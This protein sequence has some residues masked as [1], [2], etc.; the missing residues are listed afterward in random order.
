ME[1]SGRLQPTTFSGAEG[2]DAQGFLDK[3]QRMLRTIGV[4]ETSGVAFTTFQFSGAAFT[5]WETF[6]RRRP[7]SI[8]PLTWQQFSI[9]FL[10]KYVP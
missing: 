2:E 5:W 8:A 3:C 4:L 10:E 1:R 9:L 7:V 6:E